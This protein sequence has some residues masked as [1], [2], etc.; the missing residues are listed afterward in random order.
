MVIP[1]ILE[2]LVLC[3]EKTARARQHRLVALML[4]KS[5]IIIF[6]SPAGTAQILD[7][8]AVTVFANCR[9]VCIYWTGIRHIFTALTYITIR[10]IA[11]DFIIQDVHRLPHSPGAPSCRFV[12]NQGGIKVSL[13][14]LVLLFIPPHPLLCCFCLFVC[15]FSLEDSFCYS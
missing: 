3:M 11:R 10:S 7:S 2:E 9:S 8:I 6:L 5:R 15:L 12:S 14:K 4:S 1:L 13:S